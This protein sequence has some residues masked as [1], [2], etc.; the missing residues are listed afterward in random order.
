MPS[1]SQKPN[2]LLGLLPSWLRPDPATDLASMATPVGA[3]SMP[4]KFARP[5]VSQ[6]SDDL[7]AP[8]ERAVHE[9]I[10]Q[11]AEYM[12]NANPAFRENI[13]LGVKQARAQNNKRQLEMAIDTANRVASEQSNLSNLL[14]LFGDKARKFFGQ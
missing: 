7:F 8:A 13:L 11:A 4:F 10:I 9:Q 5:V 2:P 14:A 3:V 1:Y 6:W 12:K